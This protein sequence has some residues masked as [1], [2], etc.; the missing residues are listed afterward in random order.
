MIHIDEVAAL[1]S[2]PW[3]NRL[4]RDEVRREVLKAQML[5]ACQ[6]YGAATHPTAFVI[7]MVDGRL[8]LDCPPAEAVRGIRSLSDEEAQEIA[9]KRGLPNAR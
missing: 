9:R 5:D 8:H 2:A 3:I 4:V 1:R 6:R 7:T